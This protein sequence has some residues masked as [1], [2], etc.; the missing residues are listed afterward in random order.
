MFSIG[1]HRVKFHAIKPENIEYVYNGH[2]ESFLKECLNS[3]FL[4]GNLFVIE[5]LCWSLAILGTFWLAER[6][7]NRKVHD[8]IFTSFIVLC[9]INLV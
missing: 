8:F 6:P 2:I 7:A 3:T 4:D 5:F 9:S 1:L